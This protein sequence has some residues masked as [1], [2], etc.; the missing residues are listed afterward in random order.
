MEHLQLRSLATT[1]QADVCLV[2]ASDREATECVRKVTPFYDS[3]MY[4]TLSSSFISETETLVFCFGAAGLMVFL[5]QTLVPTETL[6]RKSVSS[7]EMAPPRH[8]ADDAKE[9]VARP[10][11]ARARKRREFSSETS[12][13][14][15]YAF[16]V[17]V[18]A[19]EEALSAEQAAETN[20]A[21]SAERVGV[22]SPSTPMMIQFKKLSYVVE[23]PTKKYPFGI[24]TK[25]QPRTLLSNVC[26]YFAPGQLTAV[27]GSTGSGKTTLMNVLSGRVRRGVTGQILV[28]GEAPE[29]DFAR[30]VA[31][32]L[33]DDIFFS[34]LTV[35]QTLEYQA[36]LRLPADM[37]PKE[38]SSRAKA[39]IESLN[40]TKASDTIIGGPF[41]RGIS[42]GERKRVS[43]LGNC[44]SSDS[45]F[46]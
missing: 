45:V 41:K 16:K 25:K 46:P 42:G 30:H 21:A 4:P 20:E 7:S 37:S 11:R 35:Q 26:G 18:P 13:E 24:A 5:A 8:G 3:C 40:M 27:M 6:Q 32:V 2:S 23:I 22:G 29:R 28:N 17:I 19:N 14:R 33:Q 38:K 39:M 9:L 34:F 12:A 10:K 31:Y 1:Q 15:E 43:A 44:P 36:Q